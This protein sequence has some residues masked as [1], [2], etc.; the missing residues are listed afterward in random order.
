M[1]D[2]TISLDFEAAHCIR[3][4][5]G[6]CRRLHGH[7]WRVE[8]SVCGETLNELG[9]LVDFHD[10]KDAAKGVLDELDH[11]YL[12]ELEAFCQ[13]NPTAENLARYIYEQLEQLPLLRQGDVFLT[14]VKI[15]ES[16]HSAVAYTKARANR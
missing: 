14:Q 13:L 5:P 15:W 8:V 6:K 11:H 7:N 4:Y 9:M 16:L 2:L 10:L 3:E 1:Y 12:N